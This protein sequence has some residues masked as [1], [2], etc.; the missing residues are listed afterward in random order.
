MENN[1][2]IAKTIYSQLMGLG[3]MKVWSWGA[4]KWAGGTEYLQFKVSGLKFTGIVKITLHP[5]DY[6]IIEF[7]KPLEIS[8]IHK[9]EMCYFDEMV[10]IIDNY[11]EY[12]GEHYK[13]DV[14]KVVYVF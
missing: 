2:E 9:I 10:D 1:L 5:C 14:K 8:P 13:E 11:V 4:H 12:T 6:Y 3:R 7:F